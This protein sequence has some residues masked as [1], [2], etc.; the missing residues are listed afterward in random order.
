MA[1]LKSLIRTIP[2]YP[3]PGIM[4]RDFTTLFGD[5]QG[6]KATLVRMAEP[7][8]GEPVDAV[9]GIEAT[10]PPFAVQ[11]IVE[12]ALK[13]VGGSRPEGVTITVSAVRAGAD[14]LVDI[15]DDG[16]G[17]AEDALK[18]NHGLDNLQLR[19]RALYGDRAG[20]EFVRSSAGMTV[21]LRV[22]AA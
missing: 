3:K 10:V 13:H 2:D 15:T 22:P 8:R 4:F 20:L 1:D 21:R 6:F 11:S 16:P 9:A 18:A 7:W 14:L 5:A 17:F 19:L 12:N